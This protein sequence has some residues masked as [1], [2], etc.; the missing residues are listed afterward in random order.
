MKSF[1]FVFFILCDTLYYMSCNC[2]CLSSQIS[3]R[4]A[5]QLNLGNAS[6]KCK[7][8]NQQTDTISSNHHHIIKHINKSIKMFNITVSRG[9]DFLQIFHNN[10]MQTA[11]KKKYRLL[12][13]NNL[14]SLKPFFISEGLNYLHFIPTKTN[15][16]SMSKILCNFRTTVEMVW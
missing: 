14:P 1:K 13:H 9:F 5:F 4:L 16:F 3:F 2:S 8:N 10:V 6:Q 11:L 15:H 7:R 12:N